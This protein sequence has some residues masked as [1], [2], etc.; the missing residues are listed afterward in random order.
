MASRPRGKPAESATLGRVQSAVFHLRA[1]RRLKI[2]KQLEP[3]HLLG[4]N[5]QNT[6]LVDKT[7]Q[8]DLNKTEAEPKQTTV[9]RVCVLP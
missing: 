3:T 9:L 2:C 4:D 1:F 7:K 5:K 8:I 6:D